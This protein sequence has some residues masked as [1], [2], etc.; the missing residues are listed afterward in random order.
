[1]F[2]HEER[3]KAV[4]LYLKYE[5]WAAVISELGY[6]NRSTLRNWVKEYQENE[7]LHKK[8]TRKEKYSEEEKSLAVNYY[9][10]HG[11]NISKTLRALGYPSRN[12]LKQWILE[13]CPDSFRTCTTH[14]SLV[15]LSVD[16]KEKA[17][18]EFCERRIP[19]T[20]IAQKYKI[21]R[22]S[23]YNWKKELLG[24]K[25]V[26]K[27]PKKKVISDVQ[28]LKNEINN[29]TAQA[30]DLRQQIYRLQLE[31]DVLEKAAEIIKKDQGITLQTLTNR[32]KAIVIDTLFVLI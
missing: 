17:V 32:E 15:H 18:I 13:R 6:P 3:T 16:K 26:P 9:L 31:K 11:K 4:E 27:M 20:K 1:M 14:K 23:L 29:L 30:D 7:S 8:Q 2:S 28:E 12:Y 21:N 10:E 22:T 5:S 19:A 25:D 24:D